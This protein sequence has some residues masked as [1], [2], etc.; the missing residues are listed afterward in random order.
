MPHRSIVPATVAQLRKNNAFRQ[1]FKAA[2]TELSLARGRPMD[3]KVEST[4]LADA[5]R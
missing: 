4:T 3:C 5:S 1:D 2:Q